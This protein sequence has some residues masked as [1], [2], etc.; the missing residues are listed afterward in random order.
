M[1]HGDVRD[2][3]VVVRTYSYRHEAEVGRAMLEA[4]GVDAMIMADDFGGMRPDV[5]A[6]TGVR[7][8]VR[9]EDEDTATK[10]IG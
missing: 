2:K 5:G 10:L 3:L 9:R 8:V 4:N 6:H 1:T 7:L